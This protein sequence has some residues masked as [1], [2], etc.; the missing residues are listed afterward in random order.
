M[1]AFIEGRVCE[2]GNGSLVIQAGG[3]GLDRKSVV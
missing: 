1:F 3:I 2:K